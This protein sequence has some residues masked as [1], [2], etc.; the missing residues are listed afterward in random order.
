MLYVFACTRMLIIAQTW[1][2]FEST[3]TVEWINVLLL[4]PYMEI[5]TAMTIFKATTICNHMYKSHKQCN[6]KQK[7][8]ERKHFA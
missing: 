3:S 5:C 7:K 6:N 4:L 2:P 8:S 1:K